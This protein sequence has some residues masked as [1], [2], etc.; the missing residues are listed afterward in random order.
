M[1]ISDE[2]KFVFLHIPKTAGSSLRKILT[3]YASEYP[4][5]Y[6][7]I[8]GHPYH[9]TQT[10][11]VN[12]YADKDFSDYLEFF[13][14]REPLQRL[15][16][17]Y[18]HGRQE[19]FGSFYKLALHVSSCKNNQESNFFYRSQLEWVRNPLC[20]K[21]KYYKFEDT[22]LLETVSSDLNVT[23]LDA[24]ESNNEKTFTMENLTD[25]ELNF[26]MDFLSDEYEYFGYE[27]VL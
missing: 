15:I 4:V 8:L 11:I 14:V 16:S 26:C 24:H 9:I 13:V 20:G 7:R 25:K 27:K 23:F 2:K 1:I 17:I 21:S 5:T 22:T 18:N 19:L 12:C 3:P 10:E 6:R